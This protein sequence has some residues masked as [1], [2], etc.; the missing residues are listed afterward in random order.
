QLNGILKLDYN[1]TS[2]GTLPWVFPRILNGK[3]LDYSSRITGMLP[4]SIK[5]AYYKRSI[6]NT[7]GEHPSGLKPKESIFSS[8]VTIKS[9][10]FERIIT[11]TIIVK[12]NIK[13]M[14]SNNQV[15]F[16]DG[17]ILEDIDAIVY[18]TGYNIEFPF[19]D[20]AIVSG[21]EEIEK[22]FDEEYRENLVWM[23]KMMFPPKYPNIAF[24]GLVQPNGPIFPAA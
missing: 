10:L 15:E 5:A 24:V 20:R 3:P 11:G 19:L 22:E 2:T 6:R 14:K 9:S 18:A 4:S 23:Y 8:H 7:I 1:P 13:E 12:Q 16:V 17:S 21:G